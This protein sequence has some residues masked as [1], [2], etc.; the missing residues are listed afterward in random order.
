M[1]RREQLEGMLA[2]SPDDTFLRYALAM[3]LQNEGEH[4]RSLELHRGL[5]NEEPPYVPSFFMSGQQLSNLDRID[6]AKE[7][8]KAGI[9]QAT[10][11]N[12]LHAAGEMRGFLDSLE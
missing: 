7:A 6:E 5:M 12:D 2:E 10:A 3:E 11:Q 4:E 8:L 1:S 9:E